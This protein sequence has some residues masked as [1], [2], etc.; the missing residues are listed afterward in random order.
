MSKAAVDWKEQRRMQA[1]ELKYQ[2]WKQ[3]DIATA[4]GVSKGAVS[5]WINL[6]RTSGS[7]AL[8][9]QPH[10]GRPAELTLAQKRLLPDV[11]SHGAEAYGFQG[12]VWTCSRVAQ[13]IEQE[14]QV[15]SHK[16]HVAR[17]LKELDWTPQR[18]I[19]RASQRD[20]AEIARWRTEVWPELKKKLSWS[21]VT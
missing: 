18:P 14:W 6:A 3:S 1:L 16:S 13:V 17:L 11:L 5:Q 10:T 2:H 4:L 15:C 8:W 21:A 7:A 19:E 9:A 12:E 20:E